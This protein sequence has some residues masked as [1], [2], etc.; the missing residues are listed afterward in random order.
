MA[1][2]QAQYLRLFSGATTYARWQ[3]SYHQQSVSWEGQQWP[4]QQFDVDGLVEGA[5]GDE[6]GL[7]IELPATA[8]VVAIIETALRE[9]WLAE[10][11]SYEFNS[12]AGDNTPQ[13]GQVLIASAVGEVVGASG[14]LT[15]IQL[16]LGSSL[17]PVGAQVPP[18]SYTTPLVGVPCLL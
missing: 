10:M 16:E 4:W 5:S 1:R 14:T 13:A 11:R 8:D 7:N 15:T 2:A 6:T 12:L 9:S 3:N 17:S 18:R